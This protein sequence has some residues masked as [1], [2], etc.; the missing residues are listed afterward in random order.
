MTHW[1]MINLNVA[2]IQV[3]ALINSWLGLRLGLAPTFKLLVHRIQLRLE[4]PVKIWKSRSDQIKEVPF[5]SN[6]VGLNQASSCSSLAHQ[7]K[8]KLD[9]IPNL[10]LLPNNLNAL[11]NP[12]PLHS[13]EIPFAVFLKME[14]CA[15][16]F[17]PS[18]HPHL[19][20]IAS[21]PGYC[22]CCQCCSLTGTVFIVHATCCQH[23]LLPIPLCAP[24]PLSKQWCSD[25]ALKGTVNSDPIVAP[26]VL[27]QPFWQDMVDTKI[28]FLHGMVFY[29]LHCISHWHKTLF[30]FV[31]SRFS[32]WCGQS[33]LWVNITVLLET[34]EIEFSHIYSK[35][36]MNGCFCSLCYKQFGN[37]EFDCSMHDAG[38]FKCYLV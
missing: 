3:K 27:Q 34:R 4:P 19:V 22:P 2:H 35:F 29:S 30:F 25:Q 5:K 8:Q 24:S 10:Q 7:S 16:F 26:I 17:P 1:Q 31:H 21:I 28:W 11:C 6:L 20:S 15:K 38:E 14:T 18:S 32:H 36:S 23:S 13:P 33:C 37:H 9:V 12:Q